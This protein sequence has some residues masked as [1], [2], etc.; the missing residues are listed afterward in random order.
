MLQ[1][2]SPYLN[3]GFFLVR[4]GV[5]F[6][7]WFVLRVPARPASPR[8]RTGASD[9]GPSRRLQR[10]SG[11]GLVLLFLT[12]T[13]AAIDWMMSLEPHWVSTIY[14]AMV[15]VGEGAGDAGDDDRRR[16]LAVRPPADGRGGRRPDRLHDLGNLMLAFTMLWAYMSFSQYLIIWSGNLP[17]EIP[18]YLRR[19]RGGWQWVA[20]ALIVFHFFLPFFVLLF[21]ENK[22]QS[23]LLVR[24]AAWSWR[25]TGSTWSG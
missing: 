19:T 13:F 2:K 22:R 14:G 6:A 3:A 11:P 5:Y 20:L 17:E 10:L 8:R 15:V 24:V 23:R 1:A 9:H 21:R 12:G 25:C 4:T 18:W 16:G 7:I